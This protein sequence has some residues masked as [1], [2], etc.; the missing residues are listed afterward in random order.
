MF[1][2]SYTFR[3]SSNKVSVAESVE[4]LQGKMEILR[5]PQRLNCIPHSIRLK[6]VL[7]LPMTPLE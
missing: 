4:V 2:F 5:P 3:E 6:V 1:F 7:F